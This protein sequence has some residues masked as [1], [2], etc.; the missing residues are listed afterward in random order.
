MNSDT[1]FVNFSTKSKKNANSC[2]ERVSNQTETIVVISRVEFLAAG[3]TSDRALHRA[4]TFDLGKTGRTNV[5][6]FAFHPA[7]FERQ[8]MTRAFTRIPSS[9]QAICHSMPCGS[10]WRRPLRSNANKCANSCLSVLQTCASDRSLSLGLISIKRVGHHARP[11]VV[12]ILGFHTT[13]TF[14]ASSGSPNDIACSR[15][16]T[17]IPGSEF[18]KESVRRLFFFGIFTPRAHLGNLNSNCEKKCAI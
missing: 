18:S 16:Q 8:G 7:A 10:I 15:H 6:I 1:N 11:A 12:R 3:I 17:V 2:S 5:N 13:R 9:E 14:L 4:N